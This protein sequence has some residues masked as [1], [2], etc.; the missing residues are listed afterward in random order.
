MNFEKLRDFIHPNSPIERVL[1]ENQSRANNFGQ[2]ADYWEFDIKDVLN[3]FLKSM[4]KYA[5]YGVFL[6]SLIGI[7]F[8]VDGQKKY[9]YQPEKV[10]SNTKEVAH[11]ADETSPGAELSPGSDFHKNEDPHQKVN[12]NWLFGITTDLSLDGETLGGFIALIVGIAIS[13]GG[14]MVAIMISWRTM[15]LGLHMKEIEESKF[16]LDYHEKIGEKLSVYSNLP[17]EDIDN[18]FLF[19]NGLLEKARSY[20]GRG[21][22]FDEKS[23]EEARKIFENFFNAVS[24]IEADYP[25]LFPTEEGI[26][27]VIKSPS[28]AAWNIRSFLDCSYF[29]LVCELTSKMPIEFLKDG[30]GIKDIEKIFDNQKNKDCIV[31]IFAMSFLCEISRGNIGDLNSLVR[32]WRSHL[33]FGNECIQNRVAKEY[34]GY[35]FVRN[36][37]A[38]VADGKRIGIR[39]SNYLSDDSRLLIGKAERLIGKFDFKDYADEL[40]MKIQDFRELLAGR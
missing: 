1:K 21:K 24:K 28:S 39:Y 4:L 22:V 33:F 3:A 10:E 6:V 36:V 11:P 16:Y 13:V 40:H 20:N 14:A 32:R 8:Y 19:F 29:R 38:K 7:L 34:G 30:S 12:Q 26:K 2:R 5:I 18:F 25:E 23:A 35:V 31:F 15:E 17:L 27:A 37:V 9:I